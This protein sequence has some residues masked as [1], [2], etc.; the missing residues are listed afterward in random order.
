MVELG[1]T[2]YWDVYKEIK[3]FYLK[4][5]EGLSFRV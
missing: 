2:N 3:A 5:L 1:I 4:G